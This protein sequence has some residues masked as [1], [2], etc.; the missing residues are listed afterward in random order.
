MVQLGR[1]VSAPRLMRLSAS[2][3]LSMNSRS[4]VSLPLALPVVE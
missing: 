1:F 3:P 4:S 2:M